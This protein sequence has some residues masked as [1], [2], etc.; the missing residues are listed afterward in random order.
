M[1]GLSFRQGT[2]YTNEHG[3]G[4]LL[5]NHN[6]M[7]LQSL[8]IPGE[9]GVFDCAKAA[10]LAIDELIVIRQK[11]ELQDRGDVPQEVLV[12]ILTEV[13]KKANLAEGDRQLLETL[14][15]EFRHE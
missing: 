4:F 2:L 14:L 10:L 5:I 1:A 3:R 8:Q 13:L 15:Q 12:Q 6:P 9:N 7:A 11:G